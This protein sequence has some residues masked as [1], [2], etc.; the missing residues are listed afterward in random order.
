MHTHIHTHARGEIYTHIGAHTYKRVITYLFRLERC[1]SDGG[2]D[3][4][5]HYK[6]RTRLVN[7]APQTVKREKRLQI[8]I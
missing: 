5:I 2:G 3:G 7:D 8:G 1:I 6:L 4:G